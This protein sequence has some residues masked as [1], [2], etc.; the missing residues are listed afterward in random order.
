MK[1][2]YKVALCIMVCYLVAWLDRMCISMTIP[3]MMKD[4]NFSATAAGSIMGAF[5]LTYSLFHMPG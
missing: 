3:F 4:L 5:F 1:D 2:K